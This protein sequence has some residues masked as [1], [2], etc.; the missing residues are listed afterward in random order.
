M[1]DILDVVSQNYLKACKVKSCLPFLLVNSVDGKVVRYYRCLTSEFD[2]L[3]L[4][5]SWKRKPTR[6]LPRLL[7]KTMEETPLDSSKCPG[8]MKSVFMSK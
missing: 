6:I 8:E 2:T 1:T 4:L 7:G 3:T 5:L